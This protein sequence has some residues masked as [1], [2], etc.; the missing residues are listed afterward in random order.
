MNIFVPIVHLFFPIYD[1][2]TTYKHFVILCMSN[3]CW[4]ITLFEDFVL[5]TGHPFLHEFQVIHCVPNIRIHTQ[6]SFQDRS[7]KNRGFGGFPM[8]SAAFM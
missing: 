5:S 3:V 1:L 8:S 7:S 2:V 4:A 6:H